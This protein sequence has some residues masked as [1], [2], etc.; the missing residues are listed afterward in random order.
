MEPQQ[1]HIRAEGRTWWVQKGWHAPVERG[2][3]KRTEWGGGGNETSVSRG[4]SE[5]R[6]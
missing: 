3:R 5:G 2:L 6:H 1:K 4:G